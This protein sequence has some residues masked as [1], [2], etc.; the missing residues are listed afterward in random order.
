MFKRLKIGP[1]SAINNPKS[2]F[3]Y[4]YI[5]LYI[6]FSNKTSN[7]TNVSSNLYNNFDVDR[8]AD[9]TSKLL[10]ATCTSLLINIRPI[11]AERTVWHQ[12]VHQSVP[13]DN[14][15][16]LMINWP[17]GW[18]FHAKIHTKII[19]I[20]FL[21]DQIRTYICKCKYVT[22]TYSFIYFNIWLSV[23][24]RFYWHDIALS[25]IHANISN[26]RCGIN[27]KLLNLRCILKLNHTPFLQS[28]VVGFIHEFQNCY[29]KQGAKTAFSSKK[30][31]DWYKWILSNSKR[32]IYIFVDMTD[33]NTKINCISLEC[34]TT[35][36][37]VHNYDC[38]A[39]YHPLCSTTTLGKA[40]GSF[41][42]IIE[43]FGPTCSNYTIFMLNVW[44]CWFIMIKDLKLHFYVRI[45]ACL[46]A[47]T[48]M[49][50]IV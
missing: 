49:Q 29:R 40:L 5:L 9:P 14:K 41:M 1:K 17:K 45:C 35:P 23:A 37:F 18:P 27:V 36:T 47:S 19:I 48:S 39:F 25:M 46:S 38:D 4:P 50:M 33:L 42:Y 26:G 24:C 30:V 6:V 31:L 21:W 3:L 32:F 16:L 15:C 12:T 10:T 8:S 20:A 34:G 44:W 28:S 11:T 2:I 22:I 43:F 13:R 7:K